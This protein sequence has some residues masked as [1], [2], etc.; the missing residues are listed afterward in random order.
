MGFDR[1]GL[2]FVSTRPGELSG[3][4]GT[5]ENGQTRDERACSARLA[6]GLA[7]AQQLEEVAC[8]VGLPIQAVSVAEIA[9]SIVAQYV[10]QRAQKVLGR[11]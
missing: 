10:Q 7:T 2:W 6:D 9:V 4:F 8:P 11:G 5:D 1:L 3:S